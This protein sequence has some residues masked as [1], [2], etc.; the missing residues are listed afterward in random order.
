MLLSEPENTGISIAGTSFDAVLLPDG[1]RPDFTDVKDLRAR[2]PEMIFVEI[3]STKKESVKDDVSG[4]FFSL[5]EK[6]IDAAHQLGHRHIV[7]LHNLLTGALRLIGSPHSTRMVAFPPRAP[8]AS[9]VL[10]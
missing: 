4:F 3:K 6:E 7:L 5:T 8:P 10:N 2:L 1:Y 9:S